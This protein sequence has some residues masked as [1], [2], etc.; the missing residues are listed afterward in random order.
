MGMKFFVEMMMFES[1]HG[2]AAAKLWGPVGESIQKIAKSGKMVDGAIFAGQRGGYF[3]VD[4][5]SAA[6]IDDLFAPTLIDNFKVNCYPL[7]TFEEIGKL[8]KRMIAEKK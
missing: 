8:F 6:E 2:D 3:I 4:V 7:M 5:N 1:I